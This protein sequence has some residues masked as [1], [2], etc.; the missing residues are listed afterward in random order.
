MCGLATFT[1]ICGPRSGALPTL[2]LGAG[3]DGNGRGHAYPPEVWLQIPENDT[4][5]LWPGGGVPRE[6]N[7]DILCVQHEYG[8]FG[9]PMGSG[10]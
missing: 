10:C 6:V 3:H 2:M 8:I 4:R 9:D 7:A 5:A 1:A